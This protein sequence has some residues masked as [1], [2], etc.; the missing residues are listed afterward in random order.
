MTDRAASIA[1]VA[2]FMLIMAL[3]YAGRQRLTT[4]CV[5]TIVD[6]HYA[7]PEGTIPETLSIVDGTT[8]CRC[9]GR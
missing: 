7:C 5:E 3:A 2:M 1:W 4:P 8:L 6:R 9:G